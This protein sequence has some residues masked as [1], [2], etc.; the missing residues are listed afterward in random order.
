M[1]NN[2]HTRRSV[3]GSV[4]GIGLTALVSQRAS[5]EDNESKWVVIPSEE[6]YSFK[7]YGSVDV[8]VY[9]GPYNRKYALQTGLGS[10]DT[11]YLGSDD[12][13]WQADLAIGGQGAVNRYEE[14]ED[15]EQDGEPVKDI[16]EHYVNF[17]DPENG[18]VLQADP[19]HYAA[20][21]VEERT[22]HEIAEDATIELIESIATSLNAKLNAAL[23]AANVAEEIYTDDDDYALND[24]HFEW[25]FWDGYTG[26]NYA[27]EI[28]HT[29]QYAY[30][31]PTDEYHTHYVTS[32]FNT[33]GT[34]PEPSVYWEVDIDSPPSPSSMS[35]Q[36]MEEYDIDKVRVP[37]KARDKIPDDMV[38]NGHIYIGRNKVSLQT[39]DESEVSSG[40]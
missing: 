12:D 30:R 1:V 14:G 17:D 11:Y 21:P 18:V 32:G 35:T 29:I 22:P 2:N 10:S 7:D 15:P 24:P 16:G 6:D 20:H 3:V 9:D 27:D 5:A 39:I 4:A 33:D 36:E 38:I 13:E 25:S 37:E 28:Q 8:D 26:D 19:D 40:N 34:A 31:M 23:T